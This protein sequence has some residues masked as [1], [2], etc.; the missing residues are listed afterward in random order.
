VE[1]KLFCNLKILYLDLCTWAGNGGCFSVSK[2]PTKFR[3]FKLKKYSILIA[4]TWKFLIVYDFST[5]SLKLINKAIFIGSN[6]NEKTKSLNRVM[7]WL[8]DKSLG[9][10]K[11]HTLSLLWDQAAFRFWGSLFLSGLTPIYTWSE[12]VNWCMYYSSFGTFIFITNLM[13]LHIKNKV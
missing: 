13:I 11:G 9:K 5:T 1:W 2:W 3:F 8:W 7:W 12:F 10:E 6:P 4:V